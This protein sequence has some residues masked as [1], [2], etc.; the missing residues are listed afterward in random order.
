[1][2]KRKSPAGCAL[3]NGRI[4]IERSRS[5]ATAMRH[6]HAAINAGVPAAELLASMYR[7]G[8]AAGA[9]WMWRELHD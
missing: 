6:A 9:A 4:A 3:V 8:D 2:S 5:E 1:V 7:A